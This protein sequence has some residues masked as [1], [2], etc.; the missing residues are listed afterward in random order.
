MAGSKK[1]LFF[2]F[3]LISLFLT[4]VSKVPGESDGLSKVVFFVN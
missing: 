4:A 3:A 2:A 1:G